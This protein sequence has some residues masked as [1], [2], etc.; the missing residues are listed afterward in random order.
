MP[1]K[2]TR[3]RAAPG[4]RLADVAL[5]GGVGESTASRVARKQ[6]SIAPETRERVQGALERLG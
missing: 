6:G 4:G 2:A 5:A 3:R 1:E